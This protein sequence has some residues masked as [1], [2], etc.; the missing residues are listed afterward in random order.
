M[1]KFLVFVLAVAITLGFTLRGPIEQAL[2]GEANRGLIK[3]CSS[4]ET[5]T[6]YASIA[7]C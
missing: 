4:V 3:A 1:N 5:N 6:V 2:K 7:S